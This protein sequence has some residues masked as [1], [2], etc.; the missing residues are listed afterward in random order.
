MDIAST[1]SI[2][3]W[4]DSANKMSPS[5][6]LVMASVRV[7]AVKLLPPY[8]YEPSSHSAPAPAL[9]IVVF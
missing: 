3:G 4:T 5:G 8:L 1:A 7:L 9:Y 2:E 6:S